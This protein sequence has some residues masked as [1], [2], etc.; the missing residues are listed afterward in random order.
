[1]SFERK[2][3]ALIRRLLRT[4]K[5]SGIE[6]WL[7]VG[8]FVG[9]E[10]YQV[11]VRTYDIDLCLFLD[12]EEEGLENFLRM[13]V[14]TLRVNP[15]DITP[16]EQFMER[17]RKGEILVIEPAGLVNFHIDI[18]PITPNHENYRIFREA[19]D[20]RIS[21][22]WRCIQINIPTREY[23]IA[24]KLV[25]FREKDKYHLVEML[26]LYN[27]LRIRID[28]KKLNKILRKYQYLR[29]RW[30]TIL[31]IAKKDYNLW[32]TE[33]GYITQLK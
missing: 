15:K 12:P 16:W 17:I 10:F 30:E 18:I 5:R 14:K 20:N 33:K 31:S 29:D 19:F 22:H 9:E 8:M 6:K 21:A 13:L 3:V 26:R 4:V 2:R 32:L 7:L 24:L 28:I 11:S 1:M 27:I 23:W 25:G